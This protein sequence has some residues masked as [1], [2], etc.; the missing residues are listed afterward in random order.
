VHAAD[1]DLWA[2]ATIWNMPFQ[3]SLT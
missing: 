2:T 3:V 1:D